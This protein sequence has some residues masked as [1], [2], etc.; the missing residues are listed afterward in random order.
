MRIT[1][2][3]DLQGAS[4]LRAAEAGR[5]SPYD[6][7][8]GEALDRA[9]DRVGVQLFRG[10]YAGLLGPSFET[11]AEVALLGRWGAQAIGMSTV[12]EAQVGHASGMAV[13]AVSCIANAAAG[14]S[15][16]PLAHEEVVAAGRAVADDLGALLA[17]LSAE[18]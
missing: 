7:E 12:A 11:P 17:G 3:L 2:H 8:L 4:P 14:I 16:G 6:A 18:L 5:G 15:P 10:V 9:A 13:A 1:D